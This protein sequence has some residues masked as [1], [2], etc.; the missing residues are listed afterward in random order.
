MAIE[1]LAQNINL[2][3]L[4]VCTIF[5]FFMQAGFAML[6]SG[7]VRSKNTVN[8]LM[9]N[10]IDVG[11]GTLTFWLV[12]YGLMYG[13]SDSG[14]F[15]MSNFTF[16]G[17]GAESM[18]FIFQAMFAATAVTIVSGAVAERIRYMAYILVSVFICGLIYPV[19]GHWAWAGLGD[20]ISANSWVETQGWLEK[21]GFRDFAGATVVHAIGGWCALAGVIVLGSRMGRFTSEEESKKKTSNFI[22][23]HNLPIVALGAFILWAGWFAFNMGSAGEANESLGTVLMNTH[24]AGSAGCLGMIIFLVLMG[25]PIAFPTTINGGL[26]GLVAS[27]AGADVFAPGMAIIVGFAGAIIAQSGNMLLERFRLDDAVG[28]VGVHGFAG[29]WGTIA[30]GL[31]AP[32]TFFQFSQLKVQLIGV[33]A[34]FLWAFPIAFIAFKAI[35]IIMPLRVSTREERRGLDF[36]E[37]NEVGYPEFI[38]TVTHQGAN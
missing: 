25:K 30:A 15:G 36:A 14:W 7:L 13:A 2:I 12:G 19:F 24:L 26:A 16:S 32:D 10:Y 6:E 37:H 18:F 23:G 34:S 27:C 28:A 1:D 9:K 4:G 29:A 3:L 33:G 35:S 22:Y 5:V 38:T 17:T 8:V 21:M 31:L 11:V 20:A